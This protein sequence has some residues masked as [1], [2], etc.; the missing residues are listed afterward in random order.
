MGCF[1]LSWLP[2]FERI[3]EPL[4]L[5]GG[6]GG[7][8]LLL[9]EESCGLVC[10]LFL[11]RLVQRGEVRQD[12]LLLFLAHVRSLR[13]LTIFDSHSGQTKRGQDALRRRGWRVTGSTAPLLTICSIWAWVNLMPRVRRRV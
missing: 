10:E 13:L 6:S 4:P 11:P 9:V 5:F 1:F 3:G 7:F 2:A 12:P 8:G